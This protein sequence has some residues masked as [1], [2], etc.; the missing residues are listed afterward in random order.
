MNVRRWP[1]WPGLRRDLG[2]LGYGVAEEVLAAADFG[3]P[4]SRSRPF[5]LCSK[6]PPPLPKAWRRSAR[7]AVGMDGCPMTPLDGGRRAAA[8]IAKADRAIASLGPGQPLL[9]VCYRTD[10]T[11][12]WQSDRGT[13]RDRIRLLGNAVCPP[14]MESVVR[15]LAATGA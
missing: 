11:G 5:L 14:V 9:L 12:G 10:G 2:R 1:R 7:A 4:Q 15:R 6:G 13:R 3:V 8:T